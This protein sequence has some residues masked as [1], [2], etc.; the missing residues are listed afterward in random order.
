MSDSQE[1]VLKIFVVG[2]T[3]AVGGLLAD[4]LTARGDEV[5]GLVRTSEQRSAMAHRDISAV[6]GTWRPW[7]SRS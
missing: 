6:V 1:P 3:G 7:R 5:S 2:I 4:R